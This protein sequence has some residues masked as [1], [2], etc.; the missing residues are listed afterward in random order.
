MPF[1]EEQ[2]WLELLDAGNEPGLAEFAAAAGFSEPGKTAANLCMLKDAIADRRL[3]VNIARL[4]REFFKA[5]LA[6]EARV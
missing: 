1:A 3:L 6:S 2:A 4:N 5:G